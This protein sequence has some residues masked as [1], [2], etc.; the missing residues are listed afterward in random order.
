MLNEKTLTRG[1]VVFGNDIDVSTDRRT[2]AF[3]FVPM[4]VLP[5]VPSAPHREASI[6]I[7]KRG[8][9]GQLLTG[10]RSS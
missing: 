2:A 5:A 10:T 7:Q 4:P 8:R 1:E 6:E 3:N 9:A